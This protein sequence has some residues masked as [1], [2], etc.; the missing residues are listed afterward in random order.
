MS[1]FVIVPPNT[2]AAPPVA[3]PAADVVH[4]NDFWPGIN[5]SDVRDAVRL[6]TTIPAA[7]LR[8]AVRNAML[9]IA[10][11]LRTWRLEQQA[12]G[13]ATLAD[14]PARDQVDGISDYILRWT[15]AVY[16]VVGADLGERLL[17][18]SATAAG[19]DRAQAMGE[20]VSIHQRNVTY[21][22]RDFLGQPRIIAEVI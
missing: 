5:I 14:V 7:R 18:Q 11:D 9:D 21:A 3:P 12:A 8:D 15:R 17:S 1:G 19:V 16:S 10:L 2:D 20:D 6:D 13:Y 4:G 22:V